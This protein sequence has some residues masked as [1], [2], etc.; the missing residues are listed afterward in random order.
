MSSANISAKNVFKYFFLICVIFTGTYVI[1][2][3]ILPNY[4]QNNDLPSNAVLE[5]Q[6]EITNKT[7]GIEADH[8]VYYFEIN[9]SVQEQLSS[10]GYYNTFN[11]GDYV[12]SYWVD[13]TQIITKTEGKY[14]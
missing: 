2:I 13:Y 9:G 11:I 10:I 12:Y 6:G 5:W 1:L 3:Y 7:W 4:N 14:N 8:E